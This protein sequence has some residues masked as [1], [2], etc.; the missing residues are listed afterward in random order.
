MQFHVNYEDLV[1]HFEKKYGLI[2]PNQPMKNKFGL[3]FFS[4]HGMP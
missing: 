3:K 2:L 4:F 1:L